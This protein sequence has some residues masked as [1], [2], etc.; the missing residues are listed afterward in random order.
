MKS[1]K[2][3]KLFSF[4]SKKR[5]KK[6]EPDTLPKKKIPR[7]TFRKYLVEIFQSLNKNY[8]EQTQAIKKFFMIIFGYGLII[9]YCIH[10]LFQMT[11]TVFS[12][13]AWGIAYYF[14]ADEF[15]QWFRRLIAKR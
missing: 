2:L 8:P 13:F 6:S 14:V 7:K 12:L 4:K 15:V 5:K 9:N 10:F 1:K 11:F 3:N